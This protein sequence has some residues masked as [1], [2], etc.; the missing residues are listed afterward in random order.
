MS[1]SVYPSDY[2]IPLHN[3][4]RQQD[5]YYNYLLIIQMNLSHY[6]LFNSLNMYDYWIEIVFLFEMKIDIDNKKQQIEPDKL[7]NQTFC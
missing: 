2:L 4:K 5:L 6:T 3:G 1:N 7:N